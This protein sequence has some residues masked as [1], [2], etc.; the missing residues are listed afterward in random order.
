MR[1]T[2]LRLRQK[3]F[4]PGCTYAYIMTCATDNQVRALCAVAIIGLMLCIFQ[5]AKPALP[6]II[7]MWTSNLAAVLFIS[8]TVAVIR[9]S[10]KK[11]QDRLR[12]E[13]ASNEA[14][15]LFSKSLTDACRS[16]VD[17]RILDCNVAF[18][19]TFGH[20]TREELIG[21]SGIVGI[22]AKPTG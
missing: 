6:P 2:S 3:P 22:S 8:L 15:Y 13:V 11:T 5:A 19:Q 16:T 1:L 21:Q 20:V 10:V 18:C 14:R 12:V 17:G 9:V 4:A 7:G